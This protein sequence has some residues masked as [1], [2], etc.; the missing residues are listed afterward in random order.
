[1]KYCSKCGKEIADEAVI[2][3]GCGCA[4]DGKRVSAPDPMK[5]ASN[6]ASSA[7]TFLTTSI[8]VLVLGVL[9]WLFISMWIGAALLLVAELLALMPKSK[10]NSAVKR[11][12][13]NLSKAELK[14]KNK[15]IYQTLKRNRKELSACFAVGII[16]LILLVIAVIFI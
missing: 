6:A 5:M 16:A 1:M 10:V 7:K 3:I 14:A 9:C 12:L 4:V 11:A 2:C 13:P 8:I 15:E